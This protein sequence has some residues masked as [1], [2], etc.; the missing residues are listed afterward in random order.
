VLSCDDAVAWF[1]LESREA[2]AFQGLVDEL[3]PDLT[4]LGFAD[5]CGL[6]RAVTGTP[7]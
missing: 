3:D 1:L 4:A 5:L 6:A 2:R 7:P